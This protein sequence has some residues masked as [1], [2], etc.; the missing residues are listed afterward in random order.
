MG[1]LQ[2]K[3]FI[4][5]LTVA[6]FYGARLLQQRTGK[7]WVNP[8]L[9]SIVVLI[10]FL[11]ITGVSYDTYYEGGKIIDFWLQ[12]TIVA[13][14]VPLFEQLKAIRQRL[15]PILLSQVAGCVFGIVAC[16]YV[17]K[18]CGASEA[19]ILS[20]AA[21]SVTM[22]IA[23][24]VTNTLGGIPALTA[25]IVVFV[26]L[27]GNLV[28]FGLL[29]LFGVGDAKAQGLSLG[30]AS[31]ALGTARAWERGKIWG[32]YASLGIILSGIVT[33]VLAPLLIRVIM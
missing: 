28:G 7:S 25:A 11:K 4:I 5:A 22:P 6:V 29:K 16:V 26:G 24:E 1:F 2:N 27:F 15:W 23:I 33:A 10:S 14:E 12:P 9:I 31:H 19:I 32:T 8:I 20:L 13:L 3:F 18:L 17:A 21:K 30:A